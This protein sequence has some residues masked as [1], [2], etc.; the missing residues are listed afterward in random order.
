VW[1]A[2]EYAAHTRDAFGFYRDRINR[3]LDEDRPHLDTHDWDAMAE[4]RRYN[5]EEPANV[6]DGIEMVCVGL[7]DRLS[8]LAPGGWDRVGIGTSGDERPVRVLAIRAL[9]E[10]HHHLLDIG[11]SLR[12]AREA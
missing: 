3:V 4:A 9:H 8:S 10:G 5:D 12:A 6:A 7:T 1:S 2:L 11:R